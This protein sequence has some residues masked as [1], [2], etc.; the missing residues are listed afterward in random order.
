MIELIMGNVCLLTGGCGCWWQCW[1]YS[2]QWR[3][4][5]IQSSGIEWLYVTQAVTELY[6]I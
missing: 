5:N 2:S 3:V 6:I 4:G 1:Y